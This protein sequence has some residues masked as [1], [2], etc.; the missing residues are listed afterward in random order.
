MPFK[1]I[2]AFI[3]FLTACGFLNAQE[4]H[5]S[6]L[7]F[8]RFHADEASVEG[9]RL[10]FNELGCVNCHDIETGLPARKGPRLEGVMERVQ[11]DWL[12]SFLANPLSARHGSTMPQVL[13]TSDDL[14]AVIHFLGTLE[15]K[16]GIREP[17]QFCNAERGGVLYREMGCVA[18]H[19]PLSDSEQS[20][21][22]PSLKAFS[23]PHEAFPDLKKK[24]DFASLNAFLV[25]PLKT[26]PNGRMPHFDLNRDDGV[27][28]TAYLLSYQ[29][30]NSSNY[31]RIQRF[32]SDRALAKA[33]RSIVELRRCAACHEIPGVEM[34]VSVEIVKNSGGCLSLGRAGESPRY[35]LSELQRASIASFLSSRGQSE[36]AV[37]THLQTLNCLACH[38]R[39]GVGGPDAARIGYF[40]GDEGLGDTGRLP[41]PLDGVGR[42]LQAE[43]LSGVFDGENRVRPYLRTRMPQYGES[44]EHLAELLLAADVRES[45][46]KLGAGDLHAGRKLLGTEGGLNCIACHQWG[47]RQSL[48]IQGMDIRN[49]A[50]R[51]QSDW[52]ADYLINPANYRPNTLMPSFWPG[53]EASNREI[54][55]GDVHAQINAIHA[56]AAKGEGLPEGFP[57]AASREFEIVPEGRPVVLRTFMKDVGTDAIIVGFPEGVHMAYDGRHARMALMWKGRFFDAYNTWYSRFPQFEEPLGDSAIVWPAL[58]AK[59][60]K[61]R[62][63]GYQLDEQ[64]IPEF[65]LQIDGHQASERFEAIVVDGQV[66]LKRELRFDSRLEIPP[67]F[68]D[69]PAPAG[70]T[71]RKTYEPGIQTFIYQW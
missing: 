30:S 65:L 54:L 20:E 62:F 39:D 40:S 24:Y 50:Q 36:A 49:M 41:P 70:V 2:L 37:S 56:F 43:W 3:A 35:A 10:L 29:D 63:L 14:N 23:Y 44:T 5:P 6:V 7:G 11:A 22:S 46:V 52:L 27:D 53:G 67:S 19:E 21:E 68:M 34:P 1:A 4:L 32:D 8:E 66:S 16:K 48:G 47:E 31:P 33:G 57:E 9:G 55:N 45:G 13:E 71:V 60:E 42:K 17:F 51:F 58:G 18:C 25:D 59:T 69:S 64:G 12:K 38:S 26:H 15:P 61:V 28:I